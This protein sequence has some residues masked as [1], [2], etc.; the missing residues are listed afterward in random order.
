[1]TEAHDPL[2][3]PRTPRSPL[4]DDE[5]DA[6]LNPGEPAKD[7]GPQVERVTKRDDS[8]DIPPIQGEDVEPTEAERALQQENAGTT[9]DQPSQ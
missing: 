3:A 2:D 9:Y 8:H 5:P 4:R 1:M 7:P 6:P